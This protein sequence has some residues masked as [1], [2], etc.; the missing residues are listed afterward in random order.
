[1][2]ARLIC[3]TSRH[4]KRHYGIIDSR[5]RKWYLFCMAISCEHCCKQDGWSGAYAKLPATCKRTRACLKVLAAP[6]RRI[7][8]TTT[9]HYLSA[10]WM[11]ARA[12]SLRRHAMVY[13]W[14][15][16]N[17]NRANERT[18]G[19]FPLVCSSRE[20]SVRCSS[21]IKRRVIAMRPC[22]FE[23]PARHA[24]VPLA[25]LIINVAFPFS[26]VPSVLTTDNEI[27]LRV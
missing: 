9:V 3:E 8:W 22:R 18:N 1:M 20:S 26:W 15:S 10:T 7:L 2:K 23:E 14:L 19:Y 6:E 12:L 5:R 24:R 27:K 25:S 13:V 17:R 21:D 11:L 16:E 4:A